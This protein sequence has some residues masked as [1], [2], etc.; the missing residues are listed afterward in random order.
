MFTGFCFEYLYFEN[1]SVKMDLA[2][3]FD[4]FFLN[5]FLIL[6]NSNKLHYIDVL[7]C[8]TNYVEQCVCT[9][10]IH[11]STHTHT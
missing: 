4:S 5:S 3:N 1:K 6:A 2:Q 10:R 11:V 7:S 9:P 8:K